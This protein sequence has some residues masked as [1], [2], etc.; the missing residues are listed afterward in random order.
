MNISFFPAL[1][2]LA[3]DPVPNL[4]F[5]VAQLFE[6]LFGRFLPQNQAKIKDLLEAMKEDPDRD[7]QHFGER[8]L[9]KI[10]A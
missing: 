4:R 2:K 8:A 7:V 9:Q 1:E 10:S 3:K 5:N 6:K